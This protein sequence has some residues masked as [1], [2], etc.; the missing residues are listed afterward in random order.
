METE[1]FVLGETKAGPCKEDKDMVQGITCIVA[2]LSP[3]TG[4]HKLL[5]SLKDIL[6]NIN[7]I[8]SGPRTFNECRSVQCTF[9]SFSFSPYIPNCSSFVGD[10]G[11]KR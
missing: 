7:Q 5:R 4:T 9:G 3:R 11:T 6:I 2:Q 1:V 8:M 10:I